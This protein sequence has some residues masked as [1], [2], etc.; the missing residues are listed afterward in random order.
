MAAHWL[1]LADLAILML[2]AVLSHSD[3]PSKGKQPMSFQAYINNI[4]VKTGKTPND[5]RDLAEKKGLLKPGVKAT[6]VTDWLQ[7]D[8]GLGLGHARAV[9]ATL[10]PHMSKRG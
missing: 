5:F 8:F 7:K 10:K 9:Y 2:S 1:E 4:K 6:M 3:E